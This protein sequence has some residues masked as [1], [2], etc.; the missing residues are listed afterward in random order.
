M[1]LQMLSSKDEVLLGQS[2]PSIQWLVSLQGARN[3][4]TP[5]HTQREEGHLTVETETGVMQLQAPKTPKLT[6]T[7]GSWKS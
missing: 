6:S 2:G 3:L 5:R 1:S 7:T 4:E